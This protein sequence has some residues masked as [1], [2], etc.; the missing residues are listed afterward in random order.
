MASNTLLQPSLFHFRS[1][2]LER[3]E[4]DDGLMDEVG[5][6]GGGGGEL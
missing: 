3:R 4:E 6:E 1:S 5:G 2:H